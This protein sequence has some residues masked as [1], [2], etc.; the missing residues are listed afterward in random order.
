MSLS[1]SIGLFLVVLLIGSLSL[2][3]CNK[4]A[5]DAIARAESLYSEAEAAGADMYSAKKFDQAR[6][7]INEAKTLNS[8]G[9]YKAAR[10]KAEIAEIRAKSALE[11]AQRLEGTQAQD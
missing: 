3:G 8:Q 11:D 5:D 7:L 1:R 9:S 6:D 4:N 10:S 2:T